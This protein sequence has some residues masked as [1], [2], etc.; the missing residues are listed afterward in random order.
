MDAKVVLG[1]FIRKL[2]EQR[3]LTQEQLAR[4]T[5]ITYQYL[6]G[7]ENGR[8]NFSIDILESLGKAL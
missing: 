4:K 1:R 6:S 3:E 8:E 2:R 7:L 5:G